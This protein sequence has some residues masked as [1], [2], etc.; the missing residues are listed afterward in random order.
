[1]KRG[2]RVLLFLVL[3]IIILIAVAYFVLR[4]GIS[5]GGAQPTQGSPMVNIVGRSLA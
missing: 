1:M 3:V 4:G 2:S 5:L